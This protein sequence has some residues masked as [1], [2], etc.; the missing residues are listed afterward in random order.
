MPLGNILRAI[1][2]E[3][4]ASSITM[5]KLESQL[6]YAN[7]YTWHSRMYPQLAK[8]KENLLTS[9]SQQLSSC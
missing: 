7:S 5:T 6:L 3:V 1:I 8:W 9:R 4:K 2:L